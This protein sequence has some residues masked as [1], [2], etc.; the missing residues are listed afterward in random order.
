MRVEVLNAAAGSRALHGG[1]L[2]AAGGALVAPQHTS[3]LLLAR[4]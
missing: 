4:G 2:P 1:F 3:V